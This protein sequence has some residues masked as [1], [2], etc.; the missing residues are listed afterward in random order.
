[1]LLL[2]PCQA[3]V[4]VTALGGKLV[5]PEESLTFEW[6]LKAAGKKCGIKDDTSLLNAGDPC[7]GAL[8]S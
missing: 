3:I 6:M 2:Y 1:M 7:R 8:L 4:P 5:H